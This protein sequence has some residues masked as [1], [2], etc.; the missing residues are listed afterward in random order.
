MKAWIVQTFKRAAWAP[1]LVFV[2]FVAGAK[3]TDIYLLYPD[4]DMPTHFCGGMAMTYFYL[5]AICLSQNLIGK[6]PDLIKLALSL[7]L[8]AVTAIIWEFLEYL[9]DIS[10]GSKLN[11][12][13]TDIL[14]DLLFGL[15]GALFFT[16]I[17]HLYG[18]ERFC[19][20]K[21]TG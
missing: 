16:V 2:L 13:V 6:V 20:K 4:F 11:L 15:L 10:L 17:S 18:V 8:T 19:G 21:Q 9:S 3:I 1:L 7:S 14:S 5:V 12:G